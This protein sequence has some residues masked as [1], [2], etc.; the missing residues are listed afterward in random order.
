MN[1]HLR[2]DFVDDSRSDGGTSFTQAEFVRNEQF[3][4]DVAREFSEVFQ[5]ALPP[6]NQIPYGYGDLQGVLDVLY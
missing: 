4:N 2:Y 3:A 1:G 5:L 6:P